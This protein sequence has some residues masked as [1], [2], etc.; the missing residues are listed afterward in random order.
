LTL[1]GKRSDD[2]L[3][4][5]ASAEPTTSEFTIVKKTTKEPTNPNF[6]S[7]EKDVLVGHDTSTIK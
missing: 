1:F 7:F 3:E 2:T 5:R 4:D 6:G